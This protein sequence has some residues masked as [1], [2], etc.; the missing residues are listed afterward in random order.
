M[1]AE[2]R[3]SKTKKRRGGG[4]EC[5]QEEE[6]EEE[7]EESGMRL[8][9]AAEGTMSKLWRR[10]RRYIR[11]PP[12]ARRR[13]EDEFQVTSLTLTEQQLHDRYL[14][15]AEGIFDISGGVFI[16]LPQWAR[17]APAGSQAFR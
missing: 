1:G 14:L 9:Q 3:R 17:E 10:L 8:R 15:E 5:E 4:T 7:E 6:E 2:E 12:C 16:L 11:P 13:M